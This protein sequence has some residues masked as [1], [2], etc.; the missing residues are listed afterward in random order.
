M[1]DIYPS[2]KARQDSRTGLTQRQMAIID[3]MYGACVV[4]SMTVIGW[5]GYTLLA[6]I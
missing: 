5:T 2:I 3:G 6:L 4:I 1:R